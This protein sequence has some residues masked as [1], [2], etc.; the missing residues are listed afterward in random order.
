MAIAN[1]PNWIIFIGFMTIT[2]YLLMNGKESL[3]YNFPLS[4][5]T[6]PSIWTGSSLISLVTSVWEYGFYT[7]FFHFV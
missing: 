6:L 2:S 3:I 1:I 7:I 5:T 4:S